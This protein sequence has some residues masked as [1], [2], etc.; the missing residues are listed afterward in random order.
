MT[1]VL[2]ASTPASFSV[3]PGTTITSPSFTPP[4]SSLIRFKIICCDG[5][6][7]DPTI[8]NTGS[9]VGTW[10][11][12]VK[13]ATGAFSGANAT[14][15]IYEAQVS[16]GSATTVKAI[17]TTTVDIFGWAEVWTGANS[18]QTTAATVSGTPTGF[19]VTPYNTTG[20][21]TTAAGSE[22]HGIADTDSASA[23][24]SGDSG[25][26]QTGSGANAAF[27]AYKASNTGSSGTSVS[28][29][30]RSAGGPS[31]TVY[32]VAEILASG[33]A[34]AAPFVPTDL[35][36]RVTTKVIPSDFSPPNL[37]A[38]QVLKLPPF[39][40]RELP[41]QAPRAR[42]VFTDFN[43][44][45]LLADQILKAPPF[46][47]TELP[48]WAIR[49]KGNYTDFAPPNLLAQQTL[50]LPPFTQ[51]ELPGVNLRARGIDVDF[52]FP[53]L[54]SSTLRAIAA[55]LTP[56]DLSQQ[57][58][59]RWSATDFN[60]PNLSFTLPVVTNPIAPQDLSLTVNARWVPDFIPANLLTNQTLK[61]PPLAPVDATIA[62]RAK[63]VFT[64][65]S[66]PNLA[67]ST[68]VPL[69]PTTPQ[70]ISGIRIEYRWVRGDTFF[71]NLSLSTL[72]PAAVIPLLPQ[73]ISGIRLD[74]QGLR[75]DFLPPN[76]TLTL[77]VPPPI[78]AST[79]A[80]RHGTRSQARRRRQLD[81][82][83]AKLDAFR[84]QRIEADQAL[85]RAEEGEIQVRAKLLKRV[86][87]KPLT[88]PLEEYAP[89][90]KAVAQR[91][92]V[93]ERHRSI[94]E[95]I[96]A[97]QLEAERIQREI[98]DERDEE[99]ALHLMHYLMMETAWYE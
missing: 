10:R 85:M 42:G 15:Y 11:Q 19:P 73:D 60:A 78:P 83:R 82:L 50:K 66:P 64:D 16:T 99:A 75:S 1:I 35:D 67:L 33:G 56:V 80:G 93:M 81:V 54:L 90:K 94:L 89:V 2:D 3:K 46:T 58:R 45:N 57:V 18:V 5:G 59:F 72:A 62:I 44:A 32:A 70:D 24:S 41:A 98:E 65:F 20:L 68:L 25:T 14:A 30:F 17:F 23:M 86:K 63:G 43:P 22:V 53:N 37:L 36:E 31:D 47:Q 6:A 84:E 77:P 38:D 8:S 97:H 21:V 40:Q 55:P 7:S 96:R 4:N 71:P 92:V 39:V 28:L 88:K 87:V 95:Q 74:A 27:S 49:A 69:S 12:V 61:L 29:N 34:A 13:K 48:G 91:T 52:A 51:R 26:G 76:L 79:P 9:G